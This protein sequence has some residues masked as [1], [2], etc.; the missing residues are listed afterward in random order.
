MISNEPSRPRVADHRGD[1]GF[2]AVTGHRLCGGKA[3]DVPTCHT[4][5][6][7]AFWASVHK[8][9]LAFLAEFIALA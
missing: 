6:A 8:S 7:H 2:E 5:L 9:K 3:S 4:R 1:C